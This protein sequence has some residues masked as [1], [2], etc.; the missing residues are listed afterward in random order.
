MIKSGGHFY[1]E[2]KL[3][4]KQCLVWNI[5]LIIFALPKVLWMTL[6]RKG[7]IWALED[8]YDKN[9]IWFYTPRNPWN[10]GMNVV[11]V[12]FRYIRV[13]NLNL[14]NHMLVYNSAIFK[15]TEISSFFLWNP[16]SQ[17]KKVENRE[18]RK[19]YIS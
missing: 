1:I 15:L 19:S 8:S 10:Y 2:S 5:E 14:I 6:S 12:F 9:L 18:R 13:F 17:L 16:S 4:K 3:Q 7:Q 11:F